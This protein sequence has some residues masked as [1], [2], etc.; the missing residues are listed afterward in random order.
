MTFTENVISNVNV[1]LDG[2]C[3]ANIYI[4]IL[5][6]VVEHYWNSLATILRHYTPPGAPLCIVCSEIRMREKYP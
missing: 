6:I 5:R 4:H 1:L 3:S 2:V